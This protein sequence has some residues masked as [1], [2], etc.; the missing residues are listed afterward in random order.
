ML[1]SPLQ[2][3]QNEHVEC[4]LQQLNSVFVLV[5]LVHR[6]RHSTRSGSRLSTPVSWRRRNSYSS[7]SDEIG[8][9]PDIP[10]EAVRCVAC[11]THLVGA[12]AASRKERLAICPDS[13]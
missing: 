9:R 8:I 11:W 6:C 12:V 10:V 5:F 13:T 7:S 2:R 4:S 1:R 3:L